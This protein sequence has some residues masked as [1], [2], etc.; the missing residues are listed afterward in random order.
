MSTDRDLLKNLFGKSTMFKMPIS[1]MVRSR[2]FQSIMTDPLLLC[3]A[4]EYL[5]TKPIFSSTNMWWSYPVENAKKFSAAAAQEYHFDMDHLKFFNF[6]VYL[7]DIG[8][9]NGPHCYVKGSH[10]RLP[11]QFRTRGRFLDSDVKAYYKENVVELTGSKGTLL[12]VNT[13]LA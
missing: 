1:D 6:F 11:S 13:G 7:N 3:V 2:D 5:G 9:N 10:R 4:Q 12:A 8:P